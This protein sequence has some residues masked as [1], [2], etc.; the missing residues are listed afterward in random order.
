MQELIFH[1]D[2]SMSDRKRDPIVQVLMGDIRLIEGLDVYMTEGR[3]IIQHRLEVDR[4]AWN[5]VQF[6]THEIAL[7]MSG[8]D[9]GEHILTLADWPDSWFQ[10]RAIP[11][12]FK[13]TLP[14][15]LL[16]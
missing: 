5:R 3:L 7:E 13:L 16:R 14:V 8:I 12:N 9:L 6:A 15:Y 10:H 1:I 11:F 4:D 2:P